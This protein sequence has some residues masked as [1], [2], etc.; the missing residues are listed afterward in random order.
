MRDVR[1]RN[2]GGSWPFIPYGTQYWC[3][4]YPSWARAQCGIRGFPYNCWQLANHSDQ[5]HNS[6]D[7]QTADTPCW[8]SYWNSVR[9][10]RGECVSCIGFPT[11]ANRWDDIRI[12]GL[13]KEPAVITVCERNIGG[14]RI[15]RGRNVSKHSYAKQREG[16]KPRTL[17]GLAEFKSWTGCGVLNWAMPTGQGCLLSTGRPCNAAP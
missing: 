17:Y 5:L 14:I 15:E 11:V 10:N 3:S 9:N 12:A 6:N 16:R 4:D 2:R 7:W 13:L 8:P 1:W